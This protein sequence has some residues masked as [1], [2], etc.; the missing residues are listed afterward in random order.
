M[1][2]A[3]ASR[4]AI[5]TAIGRGQHR[6]LHRRP[7]VFDDP[8]GLTLAGPDW[9][10]VWT[11]LTTALPGRYVDQM[12]G[13]TVGRARY[14]EDRLR[15]YPFRQYV[16]LGAGLDS[17]AW[18]R[19]DL[20]GE[21]RVFEVDHPATQAWKRDRIGALGLPI[22]PNHL[23]VPVDFERDALLDSLVAAG[24]TPGCRRCSPGWAW[25]RISAR[26]RSRTR[27]ARWPAA[28]AAPGSVSTTS[29]RRSC[30]TPMGGRS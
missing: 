7:W 10:Q 30:G 16:V 11:R 2:V 12:V 6:Q 1:L 17:F 8:F 29:R 15:H 22:Q 9:P 20:L 5:W 19:P 28:P 13:A 4:T 21:L 14:V 27:C 23:L 24:S 26:R 25:R 18:R 3:Q